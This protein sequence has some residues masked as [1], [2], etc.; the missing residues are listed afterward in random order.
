MT[1]AVLRIVVTMMLI[2]G[3]AACSQLPPVVPTNTAAPTDTVEPTATRTV[4]PVP[5]TSTATATATPTAE[6]TT[7]ELVIDGPVAMPTLS[8]ASAD[9][10]WAFPGPIHYEGDVLD[11][12]LGADNF[13]DEEAV[14]VQIDDQPVEDMIAVAD[15]FFQPTY[16][17]N[18]AFDTTGEAGSHTITV[19][20]TS[21]PNLRFVYEFEVLP[22][23]QRPQAEA[24]AEWETLEI[25]CC[26]LHYLTNTAAA[27]DIEHIAEM[28]QEATDE[29]EGLAGRQLDGK[30]MVVLMDRMWFNGGFGGGGSIAVSY[31]DRSYSSLQGDIGLRTVLLHEATHALGGD[32]DSQFMLGEGIAVYYAGGHYKPEP[33]TERGAALYD[34]GW[35]VPLGESGFN[36]ETRYLMEALIIHYINEV[37]GADVLQ[38]FMDY[39]IEGLGEEEFVD[40]F[41]WFDEAIPAA[42]G[43]TIDEFNTDYE[44]WLDSNEPGDQLED[45]Y[46]TVMLQ[47]L[48]R[49]YQ[50]Q[51]APYPMSVFLM[52][53]ELYLDPSLIPDLIREAHAPINIAFEVLIM[54]AQQDLQAG[55]YDEVHAAIEVLRAALNEG[56]LDAGDLDEYR[57]I[58]EA[59]AAAGYEVIDIR[60]DGDTAQVQA[61]REQPV[62]ES[63]ILLRDG[64][65]WVVGE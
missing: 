34:L 60:I 29:V 54:H 52:P 65:G 33:F 2:G 7:A 32:E 62:I 51:Y 15:F 30:F 57:A 6:P 43:K 63:L 27:R 61:I 11:V 55:N 5:P 31:T 8:R 13:A 64:D 26:V 44:A 56:D 23:D 50:R 25:E 24:E 41:Q 17:I 48:R 18:N 12:I 16:R 21:D 28:A 35:W 22:A 37:Y 3:L 1:R 36:H 20:S 46:L 42:T 49:E 4:S 58:A 59:A 40:Y 53:D 19:V 10:I 39:R 9:D 47:E 45:L 14:K 38:A